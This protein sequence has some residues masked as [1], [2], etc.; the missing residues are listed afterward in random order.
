MLVQALRFGFANP[1]PKESHMNNQILKGNWTELKGKVREKWG[2]LTNDDLDVIAGRRDQ[3]V[4][5]IQKRYG[6]ALDE[7]EREVDAFLSEP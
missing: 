6:R 5:A 1:Q 3:L 4:G 7:V 2:Q